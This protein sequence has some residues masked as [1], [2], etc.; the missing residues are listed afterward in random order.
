MQRNLPFI[1]IQL[2]IHLRE[3]LFGQDSP[4]TYFAVHRCKSTRRWQKIPSCSGRK[5]T[6]EWK[7]ENCYKSP[8]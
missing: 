5:K 6:Y 4:P 3:T 1:Y 8:I 7:N 2:D